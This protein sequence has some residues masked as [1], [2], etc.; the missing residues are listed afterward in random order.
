MLVGHPA[1]QT[2]SDREGR[3]YEAVT[4]ASVER[5]R[6]VQEATAEIAEQNEL[7]RPIATSPRAGV[8]AQVAVPR[9]TCRT[10]FRTPLNAIRATH[11]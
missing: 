5:E 8:G 9:G 11:K 3:L 2:E 10:E 4:Q 6:K 7:L 1:R